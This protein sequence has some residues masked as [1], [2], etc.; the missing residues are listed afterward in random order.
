[1]V[2]AQQPFLWML[3]SNGADEE[4]RNRITPP[5]DAAGSMRLVRRHEKQTGGE[6]DY[7]KPVAEESYERSRGSNLGGLSSRSRHAVRLEQVLLDPICRPRSTRQ[8]APAHQIRRAYTSGS[9]ASPAQR[10]DPGPHDCAPKPARRGLGLAS[11]LAAGPIELAADAHSCTS[12]GRQD[13]RAP[14]R[15]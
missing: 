14:I 12:R 1:M 8:L 7:E 15:R 6:A 10:C 13:P 11:V 5:R 2:S 4:L 9:P 3:V